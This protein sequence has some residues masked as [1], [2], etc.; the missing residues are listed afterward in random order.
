[1]EVFALPFS[2]VAFPLLV[3]A[4]V[5]GII[6]WTLGPLMQAARQTPT[7]T[8]FLLSD[9][10]WL[11]AQLQFAMGAVA[12]AVPADLPT[13]SRIGALLFLTIPVAGFWYACLH[14]VAQAGIV[15]ALRRA[16]AFVVLF[17]GTVLA[18]IALPGLLLAMVVL[19]GQGPSTHNNAELSS[20]TVQLLVVAGVAFSLRWLAHWTVAAPSPLGRRD[21]R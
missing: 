1:M 17:P 5:T 11:L 8:R 9:L 2:C 15:G 10:F 13:E 18:V 19:V 20:V 7:P 21:R 16:A 4:A 3:L 14:A 6:N 12:Y